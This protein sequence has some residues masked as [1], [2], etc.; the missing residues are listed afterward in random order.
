M[1]EELS[2]RM[3]A[4]AARA[5]AN[6]RF[7]LEERDSRLE[8]AAR[9]RGVLEAV[10][11]QEPLAERIE[12][13]YSFLRPRLPELIAPVQLATLPR[14]ARED[15]EGLAAALRAFDDPALEPPERV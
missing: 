11:R 9:L 12:E 1:S 15:E 13:L 8:A 14:W 6:P 3:L 4:W 10:A 2:Q 5:R 7:Q